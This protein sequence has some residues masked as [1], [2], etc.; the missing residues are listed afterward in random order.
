MNENLPLLGNLDEPRVDSRLIAKKLGNRHRNT[1]ELVGR[2]KEH[3]QSFGVVLFKTEKPAGP[4]GGRPERYALLNENQ[5]FFLLTLSRNTPR[6]VELKR[7]L[8]QAFSE[9]RRKAALHREYLP[10]YHE[11]HDQL[12][13]LA[14]HA[15]N[16]RW[17]HVN[18]NKLMNRAAGIESGTRGTV[19][20]A[21][22]ARLMVAQEM[23]AA[24]MQGAKDHRDAYARVKAAVQ[25]LEM[26]P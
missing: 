1:I 25:P 26:L 16:P 7:R 13:L 10:E 23:A 5:A 14:A 17:P 11:L 8:V 15:S 22:L 6:V 9:A 21:R 24:A 4:A 2:Y 12:H 3:L 18:L 20:T 19:P